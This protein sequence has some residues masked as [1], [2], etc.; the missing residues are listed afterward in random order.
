[1]AAEL[2]PAS[3][4]FHQLL[5]DP[6]PQAGSHV[7]LGREEWLKNVGQ[8]AGQDAC[9][10]VLDVDT[11]KG[12]VS[13]AWFRLDTEN[14]LSAPW[15]CVDGIGDQVGKRL[16]QFSAVTVH[17]PD[18]LVFLDH[19]DLLRREACAEKSHQVFQDLND[20]HRL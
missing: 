7:S 5:G 8:V 16:P 19:Q 13:L 6:Q 12:M 9:A 4:F 18:L 14:H 3:A 20:I 1:F 11:H 17:D 10:K 2:E 15:R